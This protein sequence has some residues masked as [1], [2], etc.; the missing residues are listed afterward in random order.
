MEE[1]VGSTEVTN[2]LRGY[3]RPRSETPSWSSQSISRLGPPI[4]EP[5]PNTKAAGVLREYR[6]SWW[7]GSNQPRTPSRSSRPFHGLG[8]PIG[9]PTPPL[10]SPIGDPTPPPRSPN[11]LCGYR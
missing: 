11:V 1:G 5:D 9:D 3:W 4:G 8:L 6:Q 10:R 7:R 2:V